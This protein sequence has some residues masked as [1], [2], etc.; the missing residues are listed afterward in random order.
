[1]LEFFKSHKLK[2]I[3]AAA[4]LLFGMMLF[5]ASGD[6][7]ANIPKNL[8]EMVTTPFQTAAAWVS[9]GTGDFFDTFLNAK[10]NADENERLKSQLAE[11]NQLKIDYEQM[12][13][14]NEQLKKIAGIVD[15]NP[16]FKLAAAS[17]VSRDPADRYSSFIIDKGTLNGVAL[18][19][20]VMTESG[21][22]GIITKVG[23]TSARV[24][25]LLSP[26]I[27]VSV[28]EIASKE[29]GI[30]QGEIELSED[31]LTKMSILSGETEIKEGDLITTAG[32]SGLYPKGLPVGTVEKISSEEHGV[33]KFALVRPLSAPGTVDMVMVITDFEGQG[34]EMLDYSK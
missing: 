31:G 11:Y 23:P 32:S 6:G 4:A 8:L 33:T 12:K 19:D 3:I 30:I 17:V 5:S 18:H 27:R 21:L 22:V 26:D 15:T 1:M 28:Y 24:T 34:S 16:D 20:P 9:R 10:N 29:L 14:E 7:V 13:D 2:I 25:T